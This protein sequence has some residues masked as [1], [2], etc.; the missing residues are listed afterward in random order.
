MCDLVVIDVLLVLWYQW[1]K[2][3]IE[4][5]SEL[6]TGPMEDMRGVLIAEGLAFVCFFENAK[7][8][9]AARRQV[10]GNGG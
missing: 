3:C 9:S 7:Y 1:V 2:R 6:P 4:S 8:Y 5:G 10:L